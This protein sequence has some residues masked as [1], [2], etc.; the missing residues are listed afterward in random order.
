MRIRI[1]ATSTSPS[2]FA[3]KELT[4]WK[5]TSSSTEADSKCNP[6][7]CSA[8]Q[9]NSLAKPWH[10]PLANSTYLYQIRAIRPS[11][12]PTLAGIVRNTLAEFGANKPGT[13]YFDSTTDALYELFKQPGASYFVVEIDGK[14]AG[15]AGIYPTQGLPPDTCELVKMYL[16]PEARGLGL[17]RTLIEKS[18]ELAKDLG[19]RKIYL[20]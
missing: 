17:G 16:I 15:G 9:P 19:Y 5:P 8:K 6:Q 12:N 18:I 14:I 11:D 13:V 10:K 4:R 2:S 3:C 7:S 1:S 20:E